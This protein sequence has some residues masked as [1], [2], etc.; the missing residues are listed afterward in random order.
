MFILSYERM[1]GEFPWMGGRKEELSFIFKQTFFVLLTLFCY[2]IWHGR[3]NF[4][5]AA[6]VFGW[7]HSWFDDNGK[8]E[9]QFK[10]VNVIRS[11]QNICNHKYDNI[12]LWLLL[13]NLD[14]FKMFQ[15]DQKRGMITWNGLLEVTLVLVFF[16]KLKLKVLFT[17]VPCFFEPTPPCFI[18]LTSM[19]TLRR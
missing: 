12:K 2:Y 8:M 10:Q 5:F 13:N 1:S 16:F 18:L 17:F 3:K 14:L 15:F 4:F 9:P 6:Q 7:F 11:G 19:S